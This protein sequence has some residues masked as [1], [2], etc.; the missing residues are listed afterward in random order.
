MRLVGTLHLNDPTFL[1]FVVFLAE[2]VHGVKPEHSKR[3]IVSPSRSPKP[4]EDTTMRERSDRISCAVSTANGFAM[5]IR[6]SQATPCA[7]LNVDEKTFQEEF[8]RCWGENVR[9]LGTSVLSYL[10]WWA[11]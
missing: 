7:N 6:I 5:S 10:W 1:Q 9:V 11:L 2:D 8:V 3:K 4:R